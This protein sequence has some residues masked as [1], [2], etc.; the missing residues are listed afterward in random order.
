MVPVHDRF[1]TMA[2]NIKNEATIQQAREIAAKTGES[3]A[4]VFD[5]AVAERAQKLRAVDEELVAR[6]LRR[7]AR[8]AARL[9]PEVMAIDHGEYLYDEMGLPR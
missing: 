4:S 9:S 3:I 2:F 7:T 1:G 5:T 8:I 6:I